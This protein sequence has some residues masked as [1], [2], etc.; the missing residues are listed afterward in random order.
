MIIDYIVFCS[1]VISKFETSL[2][3]EWI[4]NI[5]IHFLPSNS[6]SLFLL[7]MIYQAL[8]LREVEKKKKANKIKV[9]P[10]WWLQKQIV[11]HYACISYVSIVK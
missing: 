4:L 5:I 3:V 9:K 1:S 10:V 8:F 11:N 2:N 7:D 6:V